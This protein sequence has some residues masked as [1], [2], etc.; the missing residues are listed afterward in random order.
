[1]KPKLCFS[2]IENIIEFR[3]I[4]YLSVEEVE[5]TFKIRDD[6]FVKLGYDNSVFCPLLT[7]VNSVFVANSY[8]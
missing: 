2:Q 4:V 5:D 8:H 3:E 6:S 7:F 1:M